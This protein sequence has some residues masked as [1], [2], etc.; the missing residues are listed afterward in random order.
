MEPP[1]NLMLEQFRL[2]RNDIATV[3]S[4]MHE[5][6]YE[7][8]QR[9]NMLESGLIDVNRGIVHLDTKIALLNVGLDNMH[10]R[11]DRAER[12]PELADD[13]N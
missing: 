6:Q 5:G 8:R 10:R 7:L 1:E 3:R 11:M 4:E 12:R 13:P 2:L 9:M